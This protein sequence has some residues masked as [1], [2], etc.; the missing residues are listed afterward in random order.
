MNNF[1]G[2]GESDMD[3]NLQ[4]LYGELESE[5]HTRSSPAT[6]LSGFTDI[7]VFPNTLDYEGPEFLHLQVH[8]AGALHAGAVAARRGPPDPADVA[9]EAERRHRGAR[10]QRS[11]TRAC[12]TPRWACAGKRPTG[13][14]SGPTCSAT[15]R[16]RARSTTPRAAPKRMPR[17]LT[18]AAGVFG[19][20]S[21]QGWASTARGTRTSCR[22]SP[23]SAWM[24]RSI[25]RWN[26]KPST[27]T[28]TALGYTHALERQRSARARPTVTCGSTRTPTLIIDPTLP[29]E[30]AFA[31]L[32]LAWQFSERAMMGA[33]WLWG[34][35]RG[36]D[37]RRWR[38]PTPADDAPLRPEPLRAPQCR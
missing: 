20:D 21:V 18:F 5:G 22:T 12:P 36:P 23:A 32:N 13:T 11:P 17:K 24:Q 10:R 16:C 4:Y 30:H 29:R 9:G 37:G 34:Q 6:T 26:W 28:A 33:E 3:Y 8:A 1:F 15:W 31:S 27:P 25:P 38:S 2:D 19:D 14:C 35:Q 7:D